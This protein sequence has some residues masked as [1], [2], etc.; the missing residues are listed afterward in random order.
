MRYHNYAIPNAKA[1]KLMPASVRNDPIFN[2][3]VEFTGG[4]RFVL[5]PNPDIVNKRTQIYTKFKSA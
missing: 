4:Y 1:L 2:V 5:N 3:P